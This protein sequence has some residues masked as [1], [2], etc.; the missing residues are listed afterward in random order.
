MPVKHETPLTKRALA[1][2]YFAFNILISYRTRRSNIEH[3]FDAMLVHTYVAQKSLTLHPPH[4]PLPTLLSIDQLAHASAMTSVRVLAQ[5]TLHVAWIE[6]VI[7][8][9]A[10]A[11]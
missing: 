2:R 3:E 8:V 5:R 7:N 11:Q 10:N 4:A 9:L 6:A 1:P